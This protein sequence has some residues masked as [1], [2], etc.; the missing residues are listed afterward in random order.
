[1]PRLLLARN[2]GQPTYTIRCSGGAGGWCLVGHHQL[3]SAAPMRLVRPDVIVFDLSGSGWAGRDR[4]DRARLANG[5][6]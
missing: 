2:A 1:V 4:R 3:R 6:V 5:R